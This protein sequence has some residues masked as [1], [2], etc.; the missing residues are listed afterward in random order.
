M[1]SYTIFLAM[2]SF[3][4]AVLTGPA[5]ATLLPTV[6]ITTLPTATQVGSEATLIAV[7]RQD[8]EARNA[9]GVMTRLTPEE[10]LRRASIYHVNRAFE[11]AR[12]HWQAL[13]NYYP[14]DP[15]VA[16]ALLGIG[17]S[18]FQSRRYSEAYNAYDRL[19]RTY[20][21]TKEGREG[22]NFS[23]AS[24]LRMGK[25]S[26]AADRYIEY[27]NSYPDGERAESAHL[28]A[29]DSLRE[30]GRS[31]DA[32]AWVTRTRQRF[33]GTPT[34]T[35][36]IFGQLRLEVSEGIW[37]RAVSTANEL[38]SRMFQKGVATSVAEVAYLRA[39]SLDRAGERDSAINAYLTVSSGIDSYYGWLASD[40][41]GA[42]VDGK[43]RP[44]LDDRVKRNQ[45]QAAAVADRY[46]VPYKQSLIS[47]AKQRKL[48]PRFV[49]AIIKQE[50]VFKPLAKSP[51]GARGLLQLTIDAA[52]KYAPNAGFSDLQEGQL[53]QPE[54]SIRIGSEYLQELSEMFPNL[55][56]AV[57]ASYNGGEDNVVRWVKRGRQKDPGVFTSE[58]GFDE[59]KA[60]VQKVMNNYRV[61]Q[62]LYT[63]D[64]TRR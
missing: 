30:A 37:K 23:A 41:L 4:S 59:T 32:L 15:R 27:V 57:A 49:L 29:I 34:E 48:D 35:N 12:E 1:N 62:Q 42:I 13:I 54:T 21:S 17:R 7:R 50:S 31:N 52:Q 45:A 22:L 16:E 33:A 26:D 55:P 56:E 63:A 5:P 20:A 14:N 39:Y 46:P 43:R 2:M 8:R 18:N 10:H 64:L 60:Y 6:P 24:L 19:A 40:R 25:A 47:A 51:A 38:S 28:N 53:Y 3:V 58:V 36:A 9:R 44:S 11:E 61:Y